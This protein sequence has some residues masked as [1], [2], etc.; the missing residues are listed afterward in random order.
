MIH[1]RLYQ[2]SAR[3]RANWRS[4]SVDGNVRVGIGWTD[5]PRREAACLDP[6]RKGHALEGLLRGY[7]SLAPAKC[8]DVAAKSAPEKC[9]ETSQDLRRLSARLR[10]SADAIWCYDIFENVGLVPKRKNVSEA[11]SLL[12]RLSNITGISG[13]WVLKYEDKR[14][15]GQLL[16]LDLG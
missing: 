9:R 6:P 13:D 10:A 16:N 8:V 3:P 15:I 7:V 1:H 14:K 5:A 4:E 2:L 12:I 11:A